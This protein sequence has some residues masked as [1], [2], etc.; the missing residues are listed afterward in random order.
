MT[1]PTLKLPELPTPSITSRRTPPDEATLSRF[2]A[3]LM[4]QSGKTFQ[5]TQLPYASTLATLAERAGNQHLLTMTM[6][7]KQA[8]LLVVAEIAKD[9]DRFGVETACRQAATKIIASGATRIAV[10]VDATNDAYATLVNAAAVTLTMASFSMPRWTQ[11]RTPKAKPI[12]LTVF[13][14]KKTPLTAAIAGARGNCLARW[15][16]AA[17]P[18]LLDAK[19]YRDVA[20][21]LAKK[22]QWKY[23]FHPFSKLKRMGAGA[24][25]A[26]AQGNENNDAGIVQLTHKSGK[27]GSK[28]IAL[29]GKGIIFDTGGTNL[30]PHGGM[31]NMHIDMGGSAV[32]LATL[33]TLAEAGAPLDIDVWLAI[34]E[35]RTGPEAFKP[36]DVVT[37]LSGKTIQTIHTDAEGRMVLAD[38]LTLASRRKPSLIMDFATLTGACVTAV[39]T[40]YSGVFS[41]RASLH[42]TL[43]RA[44]VES[45]ERV[46]PFPTGG[47]FLDML[48]GE[49][50][51]LLQCPVAGAGD[52]ILA[53]TFLR[54]F[55][56]ETI[57]WV[58]VD[59]SSCENKGG[60]GAAG[61]TI[62]G[63]GVRYAAHLLTEH[64]T[65]LIKAKRDR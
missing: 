51:D 33:L 7:G 9:A 35:N 64:A 16:G 20:A 42:P 26:V 25:V 61:T 53:A 21:Q 58:H 15:L 5:G 57:P 65:T 11:K 50:A 46:W 55:V 37:S 18:N 30:K 24:F 43:K 63:F 44:G 56:P 52:H 19:G 4:L 60:L 45:G 31:L 27:K 54:Q 48:K 1:T 22:H 32:A 47:D 2:D 49:T 8:G 14:P 28:H 38:T 62:T 41:N 40:H 36:Q 13:E 17:P 34:T 39:T 6:P 23:Q 10:V 59:L 12:K 29:V 3:V